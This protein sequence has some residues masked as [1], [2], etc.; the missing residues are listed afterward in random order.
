MIDIDADSGIHT[1]VFRHRCG[2]YHAFEPQ[3]AC[4]RLSGT[5]QVGPLGA[6]LERI[7]G[8]P[9]STYGHRLRRLRDDIS[10]EMPAGRFSSLT[11]EN[12]L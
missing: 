3:P 9:F 7:S 8:D 6:G 2:G 1:C 5:E 4:G 12:R 11:E 10:T